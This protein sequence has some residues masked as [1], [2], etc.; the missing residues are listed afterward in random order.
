MHNMKKYMVVCAVLL[1]LLAASCGK[2]RACRCVP[3]GGAEAEKTMVYMDNGMKC[4]SITRLGYDRQMDGRLERTMV[5][6]ECEEVS[7]EK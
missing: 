7:E 6:V 1:A 5:D 2:E 3:T 4:S